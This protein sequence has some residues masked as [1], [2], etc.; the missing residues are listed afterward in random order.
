MQLSL[1]IMTTVCIRLA[2]QTSAFDSPNVLLII[3]DD[4]GVANVGAYTRGTAP[5]PGDPPPTPTI[6]DLSSNGVLF[7]DAWA[8]PV[9]SSTRAATY[10]GRYGFRNGV[11]SVVQTGVDPLPLDET[12]FPELLSNA[13]YA[14]ALVGKW[15]LGVGNPVGGLD[16]ARVAGFDHYSGAPSGGL[17]DYSSWLKVVDGIAN[18]ENGYATTVNVDDALAWIELQSAPWTCTVAFNAPHSPFHDPPQELHSFDL[19]IADDTLRYKAMI[20]AMDTEIDRLLDGLGTHAANTLIIFV[21]DNGTPQPVLEAPYTTGKGDIFEGG[22]RVPFI[23]AGPMIASPN[24]ESFE[25]VHVVDIFA[26]IL[27]ATS[28]SFPNTNL[29]GVSLA[30]LLLD[31]SATLDREFI[32]TEYIPSDVQSGRFAIRDDRFKL[33]QQ[34]NGFRFYD[35][36]TDPFESDN[37]LTNHILTTNEQFRYDALLAEL[38]RLREDLCKTDL[39]SDGTIDAADAALF[40][41]TIEED[42][43]QLGDRNGDGSVDLLDYALMQTEGGNECW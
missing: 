34:V 12:I 23:I 4:L 2:A 40:A 38:G 41:E 7:R 29:D 1:S 8:T 17:P 26:T 5:D 18:V 14:N 6:D 21:G 32:Y 30:P 31:A 13:G 42:N 36:Q 3:A 20:E 28:A 33:I 43:L 10:T 22:I 9:C 35:L 25:L 19:T 27:D 39:N 15:H 11:R 24:R 16:A 37:L